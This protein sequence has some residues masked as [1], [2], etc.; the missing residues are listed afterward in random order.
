MTRLSIGDVIALPVGLTVR[1]NQADQIEVIENE[2]NVVVESTWPIVAGVGGSNH[3]ENGV[4]IAARALQPNGDYFPEGALLTFA[5]SGDFR[6][7]FI[8][9]DKPNMI[10]R[11]MH[12]TFEPVPVPPGLGATE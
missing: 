1:H 8:L 3:F 11:K 5:Q 4:M 2:V 9:P 10:L 7:E 12:R 6:P